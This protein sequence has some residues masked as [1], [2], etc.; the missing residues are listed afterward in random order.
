M[1]IDVPTKYRSKR[2]QSVLVALLFQ[3]VSHVQGHTVCRNPSGVLDP[4]FRGRCRCQ[5]GKSNLASSGSTMIRGNPAVS[6]VLAFLV[7]LE[8]SKKMDKYDHNYAVLQD[9][10]GIYDKNIFLVGGLFYHLEFDKQKMQVKL[11]HFTNLRGKQL[12]FIDATTS[13]SIP[14]GFNPFEKY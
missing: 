9:L 11:N 10:A 7:G 12:K 4:R 2:C 13:L 5:S 6:S 3:L 14:C 1:T 8:T